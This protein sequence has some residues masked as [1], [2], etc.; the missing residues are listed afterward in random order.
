MLCPCGSQLGRQNVRRKWII[1]LGVVLALVLVAGGV[2]LFGSLTD[3]LN[4]RMAENVS[5]G[6]LDVSGMTRYQAYQAVKGA[7]DQTILTQELILELPQQTLTIRPEEAQLKVDVIKA[8]TDAYR[9]GRKETATA[10]ELPLSRYLTYNEEAVRTMLKTYAARFDTTLTQSSWKLR[11]QVPDL[12]TDSYDPQAAGQTV[13]LTLGLPERHLDVEAVLEEIIAAYDRSLAGLR[14]LTLE[15]E[16]TK[17]PEQPNLEEIYRTCTISAKDDGLDLQTYALVPGTFGYH[18]DLEKAR[19]MID[20][21]D[22]GDV[23]SIPMVAYEPEIYGEAVYFRDELGACETKHNTDENR[24]INLALVCQFLDGYVIGPGE[25]FSYNMAVGER[26]E[27][28]GFKP[29]TV[30]S[31]DRKSKDFGGGV[32][33]GSSTLYNCL[34]EADMEILERH[35]HGALVTYIPLGL[36]AAVNWLTKTD[37]RFRNNSHFP[38]KIQAEVSDGYMKMKLLGTDEKDYYIEM[39]ANSYREGDYYYACSYRCQYDKQ[40][41]EL[42]SR[43]RVAFSSYVASLPG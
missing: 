21:A 17:L 13:E 4:C 22:F 18:F 30:F 3:P 29:A 2:I 5:I 38:V 8:V 32:C 10:L 40:T 25:E 41:K 31:G 20:Q 11:G 6:G 7:A 33:Q 39:E 28:R 12:N 15:V 43:D 14:K 26:T 37:L 27:E 24:N 19:Q 16:P 23:V 42:I 35:G 36:D 34:L 9:I 1:C